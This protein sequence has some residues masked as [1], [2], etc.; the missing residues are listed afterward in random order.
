MSEANESPEPTEDAAKP[1]RRE[2]AVRPRKSPKAEAAAN[3]PESTPVEK[4]QEDKSDSGDF[5]GDQ[6]SGAW[7]EPEAASVGGNSGPSETH[8]KKKRRRKGKGANSPAQGNSPQGE[9]TFPISTEGKAPDHRE[10]RP[11]Q[12]GGSIPFPQRVKHDPEQLAEKAWKIYSSEVGEEGVA[13]IGDN[14][15]KELSRRC[16]RLAEIF[17]DEQARHR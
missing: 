10:P 3:V 15:A 5:S 12:Q 16:F 4:I 2:P 14:D 17:L 9:E 13:L 7:P 11:P 8:K 6:D 1:P